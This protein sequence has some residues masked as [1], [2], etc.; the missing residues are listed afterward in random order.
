LVLNIGAGVVGV[1]AK[2]HDKVETLRGNGFQERISDEN[3]R[4]IITGFEFSRASGV[5]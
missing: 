3:L 5:P 4:G 1:I 2:H